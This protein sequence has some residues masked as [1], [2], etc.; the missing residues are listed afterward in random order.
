MR[1]VWDEPKRL[2]NLKKHGYDF[3]EV[4]EHWFDGVRYFR[5]RGR[6]WKAVGLLGDKVVTV[7]FEPLGSEAIS[8]ISLRPAKRKER[9]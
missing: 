8:I 3:S 2:T 7:I 9:E 4:T 1:I 6:R 5:A